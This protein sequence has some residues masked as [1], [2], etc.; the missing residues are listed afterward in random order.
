[1]FPLSETEICMIILAIAII[2][3][4]SIWFWPH[5]PDF[6]SRTT[7]SFNGQHRDRN[8]EKY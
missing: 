1:M 2:V 4:L 3:L 6:I 7:R 8:Q 5:K